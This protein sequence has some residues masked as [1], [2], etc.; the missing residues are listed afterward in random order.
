MDLIFFTLQ[1]VLERSRN[2]NGAGCGT[3]G[4]NAKRD[5]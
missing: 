3:S 1:H 2:L 4:I 5:P